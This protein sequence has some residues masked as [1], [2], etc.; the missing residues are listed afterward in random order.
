MVGAGYERDSTKDG[1]DSPSISRP[2]PGIG[3]TDQKLVRLDS[4]SPSIS[5]SSQ[6]MGRTCQKLMG[7]AWL[8]ISRA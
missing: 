3:G 8:K 7:L 6:G 4:G 5:R 2:N 1:A